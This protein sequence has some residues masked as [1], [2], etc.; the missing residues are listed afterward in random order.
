VAPAVPAARLFEATNIMTHA[1]V[2]SI[3]G[4]G[5]SLLVLSMVALGVVRALKKRKAA[6]VIDIDDGLSEEGGVE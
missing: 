2:F 1:S 6:T 5:V 4:A 3:V